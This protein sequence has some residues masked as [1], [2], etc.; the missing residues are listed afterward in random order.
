MKGLI[1]ESFGRAWYGSEGEGEAVEP[2]CVEQAEVVSISNTSNNPSDSDTPIQH[3]TR[4]IIAIPYPLDISPV[5]PHPSEGRTD[6]QG[7]REA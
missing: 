5:H 7:R 3:P 6:R 4:H 1:S 2:G